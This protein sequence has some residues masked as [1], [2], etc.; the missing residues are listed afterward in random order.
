MTLDKSASV[1]F[2][3]FQDLIA[4]SILVYWYAPRLP[5]LSL[6]TPLS[7][8]VICL[9]Y[10]RFF[11]GCK[12]QGISRSELPWRG[13]FQ[14]YAAWT[15][16]FA[17]IIILLTQGYSIF[18]HGL[19]DTETFFS[20]YFN[21]PLILVLYFGFIVVKRTRIV[22]LDEMPIRHFIRIAQ[23]NPEPPEK[24]LKGWHKLNILWG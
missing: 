16:L 3:W 19:W 18:I 12:R 4:S 1:V 23:E 9:V 11:Y 22:S 6:L 21:I 13:P 14:P 17:F 5:R 10:L 20:A 2:G 8:I 7:R 15:G 24:P